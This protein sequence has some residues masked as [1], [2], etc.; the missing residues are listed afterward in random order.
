MPVQLLMQTLNWSAEDILVNENLPL[1]CAV[2]S[3][4]KR[5]RR[6]NVIKSLSGY[7][8]DFYGSGWHSYFPDEPKFRFLGNIKHQEIALYS[9]RYKA[10]INFDPN[11]ECGVHD[12]VYTSTAMGTPVITNCNLAL[13][14]SQ[15]PSHL[16]YT[17]NVNEPRLNEIAD[18]LIS[19]N[20]ESNILSLEN[21]SINSWVNRMAQLIL[22]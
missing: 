15:I 22:I 20:N 2:D 14:T 16:I 4:Y 3:Y 13:E 21:L 17:Y 6:I 10:I 12:R 19:K 5:I 9:A 7:P 18:D 8:V 11:W 1:I